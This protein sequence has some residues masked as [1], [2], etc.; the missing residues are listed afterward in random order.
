MCIAIVLTLL[1][2]PC[3]APVSATPARRPI[4]DSGV[5]VSWSSGAT[6]TVPVTES[7]CTESSSGYRTGRIITDGRRV[8]EH[9]LIRG[10]QGSGDCLEFARAWIGRSGQSDPHHR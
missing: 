4:H 8:G 10:A 6:P 3:T 9:G 7:A 2:H 5:T 1:A